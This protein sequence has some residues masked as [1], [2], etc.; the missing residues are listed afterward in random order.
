MTKKILLFFLLLILLLLFFFLFSARSQ[1]IS[2]TGVFSIYFM[3]EKV[4]YEEYI[5]QEDE[6][7]YLLTVKG[8]MTKPAKMEVRELKIRLDKNFIASSF[9]FRGSVNGVEQDVSSSIREGHVE[10]IIVVGGQERQS[11]VDVR[12]DVFLLPNPIF[13][14]YLVLTKKYRCDLVE[15]TELSAYIIPQ[16]EVPFTL[17]SQEGAPCLLMVE[18]GGI[19]IELQTDDQGDLKVILI[20]AQKLEVLKTGF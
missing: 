7:G 16:L 12:R 17:E 20:P 3:E 15:R 1:E 5:W 18:L 11:A 2:E 13:S 14:P 8:R 10:N 9:L 4:G 6:G 19:K